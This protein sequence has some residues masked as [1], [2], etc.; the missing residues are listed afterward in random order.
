MISA[1]DRAKVLIEALPYLQQFREAILVIKFGGSAMEDSHLVNLVLRDIALLDV[2]GM[3]PVVV[4][5]GGKAITQKMNASGL[6]AHF[7]QGHRVTDLASIQL[8]E[9]VLDQEVNPVLVK[10]LESF[11][12]YARGI[13]GKEVFQAHQAS[14]L[15]LENGESVDLGFVGEVTHVNKK[16]LLACLRHS[17]IP[18]LSPLGCDAQGHCL[19]VNADLAAMQAAIALQATKLIYLSDVPGILRDRNDEKSLISSVNEVDVEQLKKEGVLSGG[20][21]PKIESALD[22]V[23][24][25]VGK[26]QFVDGRKPHSL[27]LELFTDAGF[28]TEIVLE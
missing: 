28:G 4:H 15:I 17:I 19:N 21:L 27:L 2:V 18:V 11:D 26:V 7:V 24:R 8:V 16:P 14:P 13:S 9:T 6:K 25:G 12:V 20:M 5:G 1:E 23:K 3:H 10:T 22:A